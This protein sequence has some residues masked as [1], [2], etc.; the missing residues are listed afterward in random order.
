MQKVIMS[1]II[2]HIPENIIREDGVL[3]A[4][5][6]GQAKYLNE[7]GFDCLVLAHDISQEYAHE[8][9]KMIKAKY[10]LKS[11]IS[12]RTN[13]NFPLFG[14]LILSR[15]LLKKF[16]DEILEFSPTHIYTRS[17]ISFLSAYFFARKHNLKHIHDVRGI[18]SEE[19]LLTKEKRRVYYYGLKVLEWFS[20]KNAYRLACVSNNMAKWI[21]VKFG[22]KPCAVIPCC[23]NFNSRVYAR[24]KV[25]E[26]LGFF[27]DDKVICY[28]GGLSKWQKIATI[29][30]IFEKLSDVNKKFKFLFLTKQVDKLKCLL[31]KSKLPQDSF[32]VI[33]CDQNE[34]CEYLNASDLG[35]IIRDDILVNNVASPVKIG[36]YLGSGIPVALSNGVGDF[37]ESLTRAGV[38]LCLSEDN[39]VE[40][41]HHFLKSTDFEV[42]SEKC[43]KYSNEKL[44]WSSFNAEF[45][46]LYY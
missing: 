33:C 9:R 11:L 30:S 1:R 42:L 13:R 43:F 22:R 46:N 6:L 15:E 32:L 5:V 41:I 29:I 35:I 23:T 36:E 38:G 21:E 8:T 2:Y 19:S 39:Y 27:F 14:N 7:V 45:K 26:K 3:R 20:I 17:C 31:D 25:R 4:Q 34:V 12:K 24:Q 44:S 40:Q 16:E 28:S 18:P 37:S 10:G